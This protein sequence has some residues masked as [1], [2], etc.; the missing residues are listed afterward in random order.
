MK[1]LRYRPKP[2][3]VL[4]CINSSLGVRRG[5]PNTFLLCKVPP[6]PEPVNPELPKWF[7]SEAVSSKS[8]NFKIEIQ[9]EFFREP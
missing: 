6:L 4:E 5:A 2:T 7:S 3:N 8:L 9:K 1:A